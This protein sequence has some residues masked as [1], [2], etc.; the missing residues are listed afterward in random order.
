MRL[1]ALAAAL[2][3]SSV[4]FK[5]ASQAPAPAKPADAAQGNQTAGPPAQGNPAA[6][7]SASSAERRFRIQQ[8]IVVPPQKADAT[9]FIP[10]PH[11]DQWQTIS[12][13]QLPEGAETVRD[14]LGNVAARVK[15]PAAGSELKL[16]F[17]VDRRERAAK[18]DAPAKPVGRPADLARWLKDDKLVQ[19]DD[20]IRKIA[21]DQTRNARTPLDKARAIYA[22]VVSTMKYQKT[23]DGWGNGSIVWACDAKYGNCTDFHALLIGLLRAEG[24]P[25]RFEIGRSVPPA[26]GAVAGYHCWADFW[27]D[28]IGWVPVD[29]SEAWKHPDR[30]DYFFGHHDDDRFALSQGR[31]LRLPGLAGEPLNYFVDPV[32]EVGGSRA[33][34][35]KQTTQVTAL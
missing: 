29:A 3:S 18:F 13:L 33:Q 30:R 7:G 35:V 4:P 16:A 26:S 32:A 11:D 22:Y 12:G 14:A 31:D 21:A 5:T 9:V 15:V 2:L 27:L 10:V 8:S 6:G 1:L 20:R 34:G 19:V 24:I 17:D 25:A 28:G 23:G